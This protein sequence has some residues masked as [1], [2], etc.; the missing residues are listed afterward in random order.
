MLEKFV[1]MLR[2]TALGMSAFNIFV[3]IFILMG[4]FLSFKVP[5]NWFRLIL[6]FFVSDI[7]QNL[8]IFGTKFK[9]INTSKSGN[10]KDID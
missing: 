7:F 1:K 9:D 5:P 3:I 10:N 4:S 6:V 8:M 2:I